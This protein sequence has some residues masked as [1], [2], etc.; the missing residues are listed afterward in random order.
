MSGKP[1]VLVVTPDYPPAAG[2]IQLLVDRIA[3]QAT[4]MTTRVV[5]LACTGAREYDATRPVPVRRVRTNGAPRSAAIAALNAAAVSEALRFR[6][7]TVL[8]AHIVASPAGAAL[9][10]SAGV[11]FIQYFHAKEIGTRAELARFALKRARASIVVS[12]YTR[13]LAVGAGGDPRR[14]RRIPPGVDLPP[15]MPTERRETR[16]T[17]LT[18]GVLADRYKGHDVMIRALP[19]VRAQV[20]DVQWVVIGDGPLR[21]ALERLAAAE[22]LATYVR[23]LGEVSDRERDRWLARSHVFAMPSRVPGG[24]L[25]GEGF[26]IVYLEASA[27][28]LP[29]VAG[30]VA[31]ALDAVVHGRTGLLVDPTDHVALAGAI[32][33]LLRDRDRAEALGRAGREYA[34][35]FAWPE[36]ARRVE[37]VVLEV[38]A[39]CASFS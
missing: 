1:R 14:L 19:L 4:R 33:G 36:I 28:G 15:A 2:G 5:T 35:G 18:V 22:G 20:P 25:A 13:D 32:A 23:F 37:D 11:P 21:P 24:E 8:S 3:T 34:A 29:I 27:R 16:P 31:G 38:A 6:P 7:Q 10:Q 30:G 9:Q 26:G 39:S 17:V 12:R